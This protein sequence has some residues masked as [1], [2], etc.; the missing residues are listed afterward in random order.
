MGLNIVFV[1]VAE[2]NVSWAIKLNIE[3]VHNILNLA[4]KHGCRLLIPSSVGLYVSIVITILLF[5]FIAA[6]DQKSSPNPTPDFCIQRPRS[7]YGVSKVHAELMGEYFHHKYNLD[8]RCLRFPAVISEDSNP[9]RG[10]TSKMNRKHKI[11]LGFTPFKQVMRLKCFT[12][13]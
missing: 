5:Y 10:L 6:F 11:N 8:F 3:A 2:Q 7:I 13:L 12:M 4:R 1:L 9:D